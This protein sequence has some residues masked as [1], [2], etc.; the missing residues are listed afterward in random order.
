MLVPLRLGLAIHIGLGAL[1]DAQNIPFLDPLSVPTKRV[2]GVAIAAAEKFEVT[3]FVGS[4][5]WGRCPDLA[6]QDS[7]SFFVN[8]GGL[9]AVA[10]VSVRQSGQHVG[11]HLTDGF[12]DYHVGQRVLVCGFV[13][14]D[15]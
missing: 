12:V 8:H 9:L 1:R 4:P 10:H 13:I 7:S 15:G 11:H 14:D 5:G 6:S 2:V 3:D